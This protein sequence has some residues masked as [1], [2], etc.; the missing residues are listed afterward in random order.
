MEDN[1]A[2]ATRRAKTL[3]RKA[4]RRKKRTQRFKQLVDKCTQTRCD[5][6]E[7]EMK[8]LLGIMAAFRRE[9]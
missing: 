9:L 4:V 6:P 8:E 3:T 7:S 5:V 2:M 1:K